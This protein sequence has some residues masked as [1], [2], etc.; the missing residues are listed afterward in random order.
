MVLKATPQRRRARERQGVVLALD[1]C[2]RRPDHDWHDWHT[3]I[4]SLYLAEQDHM[5]I[6]VFVNPYNF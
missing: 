2:Q 4:M 1:C 5:S 3:Q 6:S